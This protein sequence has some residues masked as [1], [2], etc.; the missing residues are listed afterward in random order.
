[1]WG[2]VFNERAVFGVVNAD[3]P[4]RPQF[5][6]IPCEKSRLCASLLTRKGQIS[7]MWVSAAERMMKTDWRG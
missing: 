3:V 6:T 2:F 4:H 1:M 7:K 5:Q